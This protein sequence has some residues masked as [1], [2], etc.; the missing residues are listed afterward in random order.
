VFGKSGMITCDDSQGFKI[1]VGKKKDYTFPPIFGDFSIKTY[2][3]AP[4]YL[5][6]APWA[7]VQTWLIL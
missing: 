1:L 7:K 6:N 4:K 5:H 3:F 2:D